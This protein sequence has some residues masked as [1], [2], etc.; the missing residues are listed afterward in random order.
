MHFKRPKVFELF[1]QLDL[2]RLQLQIVVFPISRQRNF[3]EAPGHIK[4]SAGRY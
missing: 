1:M 2:L 4:H 3:T